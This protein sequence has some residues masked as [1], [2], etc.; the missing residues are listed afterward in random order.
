MDGMPEQRVTMEAR[1]RP[2]RPRRRRRSA[3]SQLDAPPQHVRHHRGGAGGPHD[4]H[5]ARRARPE[6]C[7]DAACLRADRGGGRPRR[8][9]GGG[10]PGAWRAERAGRS[11][12]PG[13]R[14]LGQCPSHPPPRR[15]DRLC[16]C[17]LLA[18]LP[19]SGV[20]AARCARPPLCRG[21]G[22]DGRVRA[23]PPRGGAIRPRPRAG[24]ARLWRRSHRLVPSR[25]AS[26]GRPPRLQPLELR[27]RHRPPR[28]GAGDPRRA[29]E[30]CRLPRPCA[31]RLLFGRWRGALPLRQ[32]GARRLARRLAERD[33]GGG[34][35]AARFHRRRGAAGEPGAC[36]L[37][38]RRRR[39]APRRGGAARAPG[40]HRHRRHQPERGQGRRQPP[41][42]L[43]G[44][45]PDARA[46]ARGGAPPL[47][48]PLPALLRQCPGRHRALGRG[49]PARGGQSRAGRAL[50]HAA[51]R[52]HRQGSG[53]VP[54][55][56]EPGRDGDQ[57]RRRGQG[58]V[59]GAPG[60][61]ARL[62]SP[63]QVG[64]GLS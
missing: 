11:P 10:A 53:A 54:E 50:R 15:P 43:G 33:G 14:G 49:G 24:S 64:L 5:R 57:D 42:P 18:L 2:R 35:A 56:G 9:C 47:A 19:G 46:R 60:R 38:G 45:R 29:D 55:P 36:A 25:C 22:G 8:G 58:P 1:L 30:A 3:R 40:P 59:A 51:R 21:R 6:R 34:R 32:P 17:R 26:P 20:A 41:H 31:D 12:G 63:R 27:G 37:R 16:Q 13:A 62:R 44:A 52:S 7:D 61:G 4:R 48:A 39:R 23:A 28:D